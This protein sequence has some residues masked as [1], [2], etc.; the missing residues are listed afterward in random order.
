MR[1]LYL[2]FYTLSFHFR[3][4]ATCAS[5][6][7]RLCTCAESAGFNG[8]AS[9]GHRAFLAVAGANC[10]APGPA[11][12]RSGAGGEMWNMDS[13]GK[14]DNMGQRVVEIGEALPTLVS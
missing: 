13:M 8:P 11:G 14:M 9:A 2:L 3:G 5:K 7:Q 4:Q 1:V 12:V 10:L 6:R